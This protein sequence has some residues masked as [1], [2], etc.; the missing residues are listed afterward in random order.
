MFKKILFSLVLMAMGFASS[1]AQETLT[2]Y[3]GT[4]N[5]TYVPVYGLWADS[6]LKAE[7][8]MNSEDLSDMNGGTIN[9]LTWYLSSPAATS[10]GA[11]NFQIFMMEVNDP[12][13]SA[14]YGM[15]NAT[16][17]YEG[18][19]DGTQA[20][21]AIEFATPYLYQG[22]HLLI[23]VYNTV[24]GTYKGAAFA[25]M[26]VTGASVSG[27]SSSSL[28]AITPTARD[29]LPKTTFN[30][31][32]A[33]G[34]VYYKPT[35]LQATDLTPNS[36]TITWTPGADETSWNVEY[37]LSGDEEWIPAGSVST[38]EIELDV[39]ENATSYDVRVQ[40]DYG[41]GN[42]SGWATMTFTTPVCDAADMG[43]V[44]YTLTDT[45]GDGWNGNKLQ[46]V[47]HNTGAVIAEI[48][49]TSGSSAEGTVS[50]C[51]GEDYDLVWV[52]GSY[53]YETGFTVV[54]P[55][56]EIIYEFHGT[57]SSSGP[58]PT[59]GVLTTFQINRTTCPRPTELTASNI[60]YNGATLTWTP[61]NEEQDTWQV[62]YGVGV[63]NPADA[64]PMT[65]NEPTAQITGLEENT[66]YS[67]YV[68]SV[69]SAEDMSIWSNVC[70]FTTP[71]Q[72]S[73]PADLAVDYITA[74]KADATW[75]G[76]AE[77][78]NLRYRP[79]TGLNESFENEATLMQLVDADGD[80]NSWQILKITDWNMGGTPLTAAEGEYCIVSESRTIADGSYV[81][82]DNWL[83]S[84]KVNLGGT[85]SVSAADLGSG[86]AESFGV[87]V[88]L[89][90]NDYTALGENIST[91]GVMN[92]WGNY[93]FDL[94]AYAG[95][96]GY[97]AIRHQPNGTTGYILMIDAVTIDNEAGE[98]EWIVLENVTSPVTMEPLLPGTAYEVQVQGIYE[99]GNSGWC[100][101]VTFVTESADAMP[102]DLEV[103]E[104]TGSTADVTWDGSQEAYNLRYRK[105]AVTYGTAED[106][107]GVED[108]G[109]P[110]GWTTI[111]A[112][113]DGYNWAVWVLALEDGGTQVTLS[114]NSYVN[115]VGALTPDNWVITPQCKLGAQ[116]QFDAW[117]QDPS[118]A[119]EVFRVYV[120]TNGTDTTDFVAIS[121]DITA[122]GEQ[123]TYT[124]DLSEYAGQNGYI[125][126]RH[127]NVTDQ[128]ILNVTNF[129]MPGEQDDEPAGE[130]I[131]IEDVTAPYTITGLAPET[132][133]E[134][135]VQGIVDENTVT[136]WT[137]PVE[138]TTL[139][140]LR[141]DVNGD[142]NVNLNDLTALIDYLVYGTA[143]NEANA[144]AC[145]S[146]DDTTAVNM[147]DLTALI[148]YLVYGHWD[149]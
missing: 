102:I 49:M 36:A 81:T 20:E 22:G 141:G 134:V 64:V 57:G 91:P 131:V 71:L 17:V 70:T 75:T 114:S 1:F 52:S 117:G 10:W 128:Y 45:Y 39:L 3:D 130:W 104:T 40:A 82:G 87:Y 19:L 55:E 65:V 116:V 60:V 6:Y 96:E 122:T 125:A 11:A 115:N 72:F 79:M 2:V 145:S 7:F 94:S 35:N 62:V 59:A 108:G 126:I 56:G 27:Y 90:G 149:N 48:T 5:S 127:Y 89:D 99:D 113:G 51:Y 100:D 24:P 143:I 119:A 84:K 103:T 26:N 9:G 140:G 66:T 4:A 68:R 25:G 92:E 132:T 46:I 21:M 12:T 30:Y 137:A 135:E 88:S 67:A 76:D 107:T 28:D 123:T 101:A 13:I 146:A 124:F 42:L 98:A 32:P 121:P 148:N 38:P 111:D 120:S 86:Y 44:T 142:Q 14:F 97:I 139:S 15:T 33:S 47:Y 77:T 50:L 95:Q 31:M 34:V 58:S 136:E 63:F 78:Y 23:G 147:N 73:L 110:E 43:E 54:D 8:V 85:L 112:D 41:E 80:G 133:Y 93:E 138:F 53:G 118:Y 144:T 37:K 61:G 18:A 16:L 83:I 129:Y 105:A 109:L 106:F 74:K 29:F 69:C